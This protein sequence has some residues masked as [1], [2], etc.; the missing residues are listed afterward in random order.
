[1]MAVVDERCRL[2]GTENVRVADA[3]IMPDIVHGI[4]NITAA[5]VGERVAEWVIDEERASGIRRYWTSQHEPVTRLTHTSDLGQSLADLVEDASSALQ[6]GAS[7]TKARRN[8][9]GSS[10]R[11]SRAVQ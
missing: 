8:D 4:R 7:G 6:V 11:Q 1:M 3:S 2:H 10:A 9:S 5:M